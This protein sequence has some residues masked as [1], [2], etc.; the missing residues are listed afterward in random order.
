MFFKFI[1]Y[2]EINENDEVEKPFNVLKNNLKILIIFLI[3]FSSMDKSKFK[4][5]FKFYQFFFNL[6]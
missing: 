1:A 6:S 4:S 2:L 3:L 5:K